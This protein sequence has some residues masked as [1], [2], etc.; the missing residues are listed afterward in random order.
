MQLFMIVRINEHMGKK[1]LP[2]L[3]EKAQLGGVISYLLIVISADVILNSI[4]LI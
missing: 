2:Q 1:L 4:F 3:S